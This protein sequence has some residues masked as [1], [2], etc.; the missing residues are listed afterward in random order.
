MSTKIRGGEGSAE[1]LTTILMKCSKH[2]HLTTVHNRINIQSKL[3]NMLRESEFQTVCR[4][5]QGHTHTQAENCILPTTLKHPSNH[6]FIH[7]EEHKPY[8]DV[9][10]NN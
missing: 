5:P 7:Y 3:Q 10:A 1:T 4:V 9:P 8:R 2:L 6:L